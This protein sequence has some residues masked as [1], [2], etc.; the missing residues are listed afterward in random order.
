MLVEYAR[1]PRRNG[2][3]GCFQRQGELVR[4]LFQHYGLSGARPVPELHLTAVAGL[5]RIC[6]P[7]HLLQRYSVAGQVV[8]T[9]HHN[10]TPLGANLYHIAGAIRAA[11][12]PLPLADGIAAVALV[13]ADDLASGGN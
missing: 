1:L 5:Q 2:P 11:G 9:S 13:L 3:D 7:V 10:F 8:G 4:I 12:E 6:Q